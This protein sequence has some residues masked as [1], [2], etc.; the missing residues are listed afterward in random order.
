MPVADTVIE[1]SDKFIPSHRERAGHVGQFG[2]ARSME[3]AVELP[4]AIKYCAAFMALGIPPELVGIGRGLN[5]TRERGL[6]GDLEGFLPF[7]RQDLSRAMRWVDMDAVE[8]FA[9]QSA[10]W[11]QV[12]EDIGIVAE[13]TETAPGPQ[14]PDEVRHL[15]HTRNFVELYKHYNGDEQIGQEMTAEAL[16][17]AEI[18]RYLG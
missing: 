3:N 4:R 10:A 6:L 11:A 15:T 9:K 13:Y 17:A 12:K 18:R 1:I 16:K 14:T 7:L 8:Y 2:Y 5:Q